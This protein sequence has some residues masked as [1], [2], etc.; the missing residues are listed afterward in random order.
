V[1]AG[2]P[3]HEILTERPVLKLAVEADPRLARAM[4]TEVDFWSNLDRIRLEVYRNAA[5][6]YAR[7]VRTALK[8]AGMDLRAQHRFLVAKA[9]KLLPENPISEYGWNRLVCEEKNATAVGLDPTLLQWLPD[10]S[11]ISAAISKF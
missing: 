3:G 8:D 4:Q 6:S 7:A 1:K 5:K 10:V 9:E 11:L 2:R